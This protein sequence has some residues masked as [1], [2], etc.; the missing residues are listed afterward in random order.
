MDYRPAVPYDAPA[1]VDYYVVWQ[2]VEVMVQIETAIALVSMGDVTGI[3][4]P[5]GVNNSCVTIRSTVTTLFVL[6]T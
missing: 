4:T 2:S 1:G 6:P 3:G 5:Q